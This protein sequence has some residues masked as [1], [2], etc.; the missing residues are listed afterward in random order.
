MLGRGVRGIGRASA[1][2][3][4]RNGAPGNR[5][6]ARSRFNRPFHRVPVLVDLPLDLEFHPR[7]RVA[8]AGSAHPEQWP[9]PTRY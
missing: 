3:P 1:I 5:L 9:T 6:A 7:N 8:C 4:L 2:S